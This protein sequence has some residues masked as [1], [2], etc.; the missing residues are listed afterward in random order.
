MELTDEQAEY[1]YANVRYMVMSKHCLNTNEAEEMTQAVV[2]HLSK[3]WNYDASKGYSW[4]T[5]AITSIQRRIMTEMRKHW[6]DKNRQVELGDDEWKIE[7]RPDTHDADLE[8]LDDIVE[9]ETVRRLLRLKYEG[10]D[11]RDIARITGFRVRTLW[12]VFASLRTEM[13]H[14]LDTGTK[15]NCEKALAMLRRGGHG[16]KPNAYVVEFLDGNDNVIKVCDS[17]ED[18]CRD[19]GFARETIAMGKHGIHEWKGRRW[20]V[21]KKA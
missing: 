7:E 19:T 18:A 6:D 9:D 14:A 1:L 5:Y 20:R 10:Y 11:C 4:K 21:V 3:Y 8:L 16:G 15:V 17:I 12:K 13:R 2:A